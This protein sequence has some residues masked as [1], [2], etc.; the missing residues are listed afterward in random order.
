V[1]YVNGKPTS[2][3]DLL[4]RMSEIGQFKDEQKVTTNDNGRATSIFQ[5]AQGKNTI[6]F[7][8]SFGRIIKFHFSLSQ[9]NKTEITFFQGMKGNL[10]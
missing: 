10:D 7:T 1:Q 5:T 6:S 4:V 9:A 2:G 3:K 8:V